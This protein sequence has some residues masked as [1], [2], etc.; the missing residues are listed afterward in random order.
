M[1][2]D[3]FTALLDDLEGASF[4]RKTD[5]LRKAILAD[6]MVQL[7]AVARRGRAIPRVDFGVL[8]ADLAVMAKAQT[9]QAASRPE[10]RREHIDRAY[11][12]VRGAV[13][14]GNLTAL[15]TARAEARLHRLAEAIL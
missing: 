7:A 10:T 8:E 1:A 2:T 12:L 11:A 6:P 15:Q 3:H 14:A 4:R 13:A 5:A 9:V